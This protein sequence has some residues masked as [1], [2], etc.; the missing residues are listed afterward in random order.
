MCLITIHFQ[1]LLHLFII[2]HNWTVH[3]ATLNCV[4]PLDMK[5]SAFLPKPGGGLEG[6]LPMMKY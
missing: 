6:E 2:K 1:D 5:I 4:H 3:Y